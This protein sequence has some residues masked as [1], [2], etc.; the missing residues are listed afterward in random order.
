MGEA[1]SII[2]QDIVSDNVRLVPYKSFQGL[3][4]ILKSIE[5]FQS[6]GRYGRNISVACALGKH[7]LNVG[8]GQK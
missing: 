8:L 3:G 5:V 7:F 6:P 4:S 1:E 2:S